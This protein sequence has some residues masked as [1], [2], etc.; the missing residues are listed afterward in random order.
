MRPIAALIC[1]LVL[2]VSCSSG[3]QV[4]A[5]ST[6]DWP[7]FR[8]DL[9]RD[10]HP[11][12][13]TLTRD[14]L[15]HYRLRW[16]HTLNGAVDGTP[17]VVNGL[18]YAASYGGRLDAY[19]LDDGAQVWS[20]EGLGAISGTPAISG[21][22]LVVGTLTGH[23]LALDATNG[24]K[25][26]DWAAPGSRP[27]IWSSPAIHRRTVIVGV[28]SPYGDTP[29]QAGRIVAL[30]LASGALRWNLCVRG[31]CALGSGVW[32]SAAIDSAGHG[33]VGAGNP[34][35]AVVSFDVGSGQRLWT[36]TITA[37]QRRDLDV[38]ATPLIF[39][40]GT[41]EVVAVGS[42]GGTFA[43]LDVGTGKVIWARQLVAGS[44]VHGLIASPAFDGKTLYVASASPPTDLFA[45][46]PLT[47]ATRWHR[48]LGKPIYSA[49]AVGNGVVV[50][51]AGDQAGGKGGVYALSTEDGSLL[52][53]YEDT[54][55]V[56]SGP[57]ISG[58]TVVA[59]DAGGNV[60]AFG[61]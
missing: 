43:L 11:A 6:T 50:F 35:D 7:M 61:P 40:I 19:H 60:M 27:T 26:W 44:S 54:Y 13:A 10:G 12:G 4:A 47:G 1:A 37:D 59:G 46:D 17:V 23:V 38:G 32:S 8:G 42:D 31:N 55:A 49:P 45:L 41:R 36:R 48:G 9:S 56:L 16:S 21:H 24:K 20:D 57:S 53:G 5:R 51:G 18:V 25:L 14:Q 34:D 52:F 58:S 29:L 39:Q 22:T 15:K 2:G 28:A 3:A 33:F 30:D